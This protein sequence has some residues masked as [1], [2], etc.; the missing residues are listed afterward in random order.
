MLGNALVTAFKGGNTHRSSTNRTED[1]TR[2]ATI[3]LLILFGGASRMD[4][5][6]QVACQLIALS[7]IAFFWFRGIGTGTRMP[8]TALLPVAGIALLCTLQLIPLP[9]GLWAALPGRQYMAA[10][11]TALSLS[12]WRPFSI[13]PQATLAALIGMVVP[14][15][16][17]LAVRG[18][19]TRQK[20]GLVKLFAALLVLSGL[21]GIL[22]VSLNE[23][24]FFE[25]TN[26]GSAVGI[27]ANRNHQAI[28]LSLSLP[29]IM[30]IALAE[31]E[32]A[33]AMSFV[34]GSALTAAVLIAI[35]ILVNASRIGIVT[36]C[37]GALGAGAMFVS[38][39]PKSKR[40]NN[41]VADKRM[42]LTFMAGT[43]AA[44]LALIT[45]A[46]AF[47]ER[48]PGL[49]R[50]SDTDLASEG[51]I[52]YI[53][54]LART[55]R[56]FLPTGS[57]VGTF[58]RAY[59]IHEPY[60][61]LTAAYLNHAHNDAIE[62]I[63]ESGIAGALLALISLVLIGQ[64]SASAWRGKTQSFDFDLA[65]ARCATIMIA[66]LIAGSI[67]DYPLRT[68]ALG[69]VAVIALSWLAFRPSTG[70]DAG[71]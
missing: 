11:D 41:V 21:L 8:A 39:I 31:R 17:L 18:M 59:R 27:F 15:A 46:A 2:F 37:I 48:L 47:R 49:A 33:R 64:A 1:W 38:L 40:V 45:F 57:G 42:R 5:L 19:T 32:R 36:F 51:R 24:Y 68:P 20:R 13:Y 71:K 44:C 43:G 26:R 22:Q 23:P 50:L 52:Q 70:M 34:W 65:A 55:A 12:L 62:I 58:D 3:A 4:A 56:A 53:P 10:A 60:E 67:T 6:S 63:I 29:L 66:I 69:A 7:A 25:V 61:T 9:H 35:I 16:A 30:L 14:L 28:F 54:A